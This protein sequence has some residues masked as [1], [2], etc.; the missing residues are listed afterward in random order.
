MNRLSRQQVIDELLPMMKQVLTKEQHERSVKYLTGLSDYKFDQLIAEILSMAGQGKQMDIKEFASLTEKVKKQNGVTAKNSALNSYQADFLDEEENQILWK[1]ISSTKP[2]D[3]IYLK[4]KD[5]IELCTLWKKCCS[6]GQGRIPSDIFFAGNI[7]L[8]DC[9]ITVDEQDID[10]I[11]GQVCSY[12]VVIFSDYKERLAEVHDDAVYVGAIVLKTGSRTVF[13]PISVCEGVDTIMLGNCGW[14]NYPASQRQ[15]YAR[16][17]TQMDIV[18][19]GYAFLSTWYGIQIALLHPTVKDVFRHPKT[20]KVYDGNASK[21]GKRKRITRY[22]RKHTINA[23]DIEAAMYGTEREFTRHILVWYVIGHWRHYADGRKVFI[24][25]YW[26]GALRELKMNLDD[27]ERQI[28][29][30]GAYASTDIHMKEVTE[31]A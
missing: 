19:M 23:A 6:I 15:L 8:L 2:S 4:G 3:S 28:V 9:D 24:Q 1:C 25:P 10:K 30:D 16:Q 13:I 12:R 22:I 31:N 14:H 21:N 20:E 27:R 11:N 5:D 17:V 7:P 29:T 26:K 18:S